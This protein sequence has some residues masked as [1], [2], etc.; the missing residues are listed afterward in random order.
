[1]KMKLKN[2]GIPFGYNNCAK[3]KEQYENSKG[4]KEFYRKGFK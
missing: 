1:M 3:Q 4:Q 2:R